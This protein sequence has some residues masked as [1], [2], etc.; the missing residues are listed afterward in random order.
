LRINLGKSEIGPIGE[1]E[2]VERLAQLLGCQVASLPMT[3]LDLPLGASYKVVSIWNGIIE[4]MEQRLAGWKRMYLSK[5]GRLTLLKSTLSN[6]PSYYLPLFPIPVGMANR[7][8]KLQ[9]DFL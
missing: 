4:K 9:R 5:G 3:Y 7:L 8:D 6:L 1:I 2:D